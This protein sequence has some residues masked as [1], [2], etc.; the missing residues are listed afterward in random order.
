MKKIIAMLLAVVMVCALSVSAFAAEINTSNGTDSTQVYGSYVAGAQTPAYNVTV[1]WGTM[2]FVYTDNA[3]VWN[4]ED[5]KWEANGGAA[6]ALADGATNFIK[7]KS[8]SSA[9]VTATLSFAPAA[10]YT[11]GAGTFTMV[12]DD[13]T[14]TSNAFNLPVAAA[15]TAA[16]EYELT[17][18]PTTALASTVTTETAIGTITVELS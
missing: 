1:S 2:K 16:T 8:D 3:Q 13:V 4:E 5:H 18:M 14:F 6:W 10:N 7:I 12:T 11:S 9:V 17:F 15:D